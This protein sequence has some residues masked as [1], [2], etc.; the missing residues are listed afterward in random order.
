MLF[1]P[2]KPASIPISEKNERRKDAK[3]AKM[4]TFMQHSAGI[5]LAHS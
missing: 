1:A 3:M 5:P 4:P 2:E